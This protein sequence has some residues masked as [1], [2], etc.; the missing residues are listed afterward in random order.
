MFFLLTSFPLAKEQRS[1][2]NITSY[3]NIGFLSCW[4]FF[5]LAEEQKFQEKKLEKD[6]IP[7]RYNNN[8][9]FFFNF[10][11]LFFGFFSFAHE[12]KPDVLLMV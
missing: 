4:F 2:E 11:F 6:V 1:K 9:S 12:K 7:L 5:L 3:H 10:F 8:I